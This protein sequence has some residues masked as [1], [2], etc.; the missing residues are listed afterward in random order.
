MTAVEPFKLHC[1][2]AVPSP[3][4]D[5]VEHKLLARIAKQDRAALAE[6]YD[7]FQQRLFGYLFRLTNSRV[8]A[9]DV[10]QEVLLVVWRTAE[11]YRG[12]SKVSS[13]VFGIAHN[14]ALAALRH[15]H[16]DQQVGWETVAE[17]ESDEPS[18]EDDTI[19]RVNAETILKALEH[20]TPIHRSV[21]ELAIYQDFSCKE[22]AVITGVAEGTVKSRLSYA[23][24]A[25]KA[26][27]ILQNEE[28]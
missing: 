2:G 5:D 24:R 25:L 18:L 17:V 26:A 23:R 7:H 21:L 11:S 15:D 8:L 22:I 16:A 3:C 10:L 4:P 1:I 19:S 27:L 9:E 20:L 28:F 6:F 14:L 13:W 12:E